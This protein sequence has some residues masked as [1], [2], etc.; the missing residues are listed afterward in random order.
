MKKLYLIIL[1]AIFVYIAGCAAPS[2]NSSI[3]TSTPT[4]TEKIRDTLYCSVFDANDKPMPSATINISYDPSKYSDGF[5]G[6]NSSFMNRQTD[7]NGDFSIPLNK[8]V[9]FNVIVIEQLGFTSSKQDT[10]SYSTTL[11]PM[12]KCIIKPIIPTPT[13]IPTTTQNAYHVNDKFFS[14]IVK[15]LCPHILPE[16]NC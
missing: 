3:T 15:W 14:P 11:N 8:S 2:S 1:L 4:T 13:P 6:S 7:G 5:I 10:Y 12:D 9:Q 16:S